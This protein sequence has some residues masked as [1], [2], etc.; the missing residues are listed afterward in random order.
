M[1]HLMTRTDSPMRLATLALCTNPASPS[2]IVLRKLMNRTARTE[3]RTWQGL[4]LWQKAP[5]QEHF[6]LHQGCKDGICF[7]LP[8]LKICVGFRE[9][10]SLMCWFKG[11]EVWST[12]QY[13][14][15]HAE[16]IP[17]ECSKTVT[18][19][20]KEFGPKIECCEKHLSTVN[21]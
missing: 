16:Q 2:A 19:A 3:R 6:V 10:G 20:A 13:Y 5:C 1:P 8:Y 12:M 18:A 17:S 21:R 14:I 9:C 4:N 11:A 7:S 15:P